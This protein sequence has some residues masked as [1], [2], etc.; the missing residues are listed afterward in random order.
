MPS[1]ELLSYLQSSVDAK[2]RIGEFVTTGSRQF[3]LMDGITQSLA[4]RWR[5][6]G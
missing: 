3:G 5:E 2:Q 1:P 6:M 4:G